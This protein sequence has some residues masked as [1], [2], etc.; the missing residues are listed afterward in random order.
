MHRNR[1]A[2]CCRNTRLRERILPGVSEEEVVGRSEIAKSERKWKKGMVGSQ[3]GVG[4]W[5]CRHS[6]TAARLSA[7]GAQNEIQASQRR[8]L[9]RNY[10]HQH[11]HPSSEVALDDGGAQRLR[12]PREGKVDEEVDLEIRAEDGEGFGEDDEEEEKSDMLPTPTPTG[13]PPPLATVIHH[14]LR[15]RRPL[16]THLRWPMENVP[17]SL[18]LC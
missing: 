17:S 3:L 1:L 15:L 6:T 18:G 16:P 8:F 5:R 13:P 14:R 7:R 2:R 9:P 4:R 11:Q 12:A 10:Q